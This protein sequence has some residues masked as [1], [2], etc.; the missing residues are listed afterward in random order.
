MLNKTLFFLITIS[1]ICCGTSPRKK[2]SGQ[3]VSDIYQKYGSY[4]EGYEQPFTQEQKQNQSLVELQRENENLRRELKA[5]EQIKPIE[6]KPVEK[7]LNP[8][9][10]P[11]ELPPENE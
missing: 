11:E 7:P 8:V 2:S 10:S 4:K 1:L 5:K 3:S 6:I 9:V